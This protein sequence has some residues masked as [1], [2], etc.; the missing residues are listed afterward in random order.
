[1]IGGASFFLFISGLI[2]TVFSV[3]GSSLATIIDN[4][5]VSLNQPLGFGGNR[6]DR[7]ESAFEIPVASF[8]DFKIN[9]PFSVAPNFAAEPIG[10]TFDL[11]GEYLTW[12]TMGGS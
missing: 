6:L 11:P 10:P 5:P 7:L 1:M 9:T 2:V 4:K 3:K 12:T 8:D